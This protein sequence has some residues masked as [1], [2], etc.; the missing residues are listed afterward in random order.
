MVRFDAD[1]LV[2]LDAWIAQQDAAPSRPEAIRAI[3]RDRL[4]HE[5]EKPKAKPGSEKPE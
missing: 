3:L 4:V 1:Q 5:R 2:E